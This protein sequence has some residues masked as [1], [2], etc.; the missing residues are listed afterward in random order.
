MN[1]RSFFALALAAAFCPAFRRKREML[2][3]D[4][5]IPGTLTGEDYHDWLESHRSQ[6][7][8]AEESQ[9][10]MLASFEG[11]ALKWELN[12]GTRPYLN[13]GRRSIR[14]FPPLDLGRMRY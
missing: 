13:P 12:T 1:R 14:E 2:P 8:Q 3:R 7:T 10:Y 5:P 6:L 9:S 11:R 4:Q